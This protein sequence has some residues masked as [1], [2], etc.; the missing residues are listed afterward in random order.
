M[1]NLLIKQAIRTLF[2][3][4]SSHKALQ[5]SETLL[6]R[7]NELARGLSIEA[8]RLC[9]HVPPMRGVDEDMRKWSFFMIMEHNTIVNRRI[10]ATVVRLAKGERLSGTERIDPK[11]DVMPSSSADESQ[12]EYFADSIVKH[13][14]A[15]KD[16][17]NLRGT[18][19]TQHPIF[20][21]FDAHK[22]NCMFS[23]HLGLHLPQA[24]Y[25]VDRAAEQVAAPN[26]WVAAQPSF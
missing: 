23:F 26:P 16:L 11:K 21:R 14:E 25:V 24:R 13:I 12:L 2:T 15:V 4:T 22:W 6:D 20:G 1:S 19:T 17:K 9:V 10:T 8:G 5:K 7:Y 3:F 18:E